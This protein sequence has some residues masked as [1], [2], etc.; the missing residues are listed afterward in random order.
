MTAARQPRHRRA[1]RERQRRWR[2][3]QQSGCAVYQV[4]V[5]GEVLDMLVRLGWLRD[6]EATDRQQVS[7][8]ISELLADAAAKTS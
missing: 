8:A 7:R 5:T 6:S 1:S 4:T 3:R 2:E